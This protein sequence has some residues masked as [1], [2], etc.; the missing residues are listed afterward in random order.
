MSLYKINETTTISYTHT[1]L[2]T[3]SNAPTLIFLHFWGGSSST[4]SSLL[5]HLPTTIPTLILSFRGWGLSSGPSSPTS[6]SILHLAQDVE[7]LISHLDIK[8]FV[9]IGHSMGGKVAQLIAGQKRVKGLKGMV[10]LAPAPPTPLVL[11]EEMK[12]QQLT[13][14]D[15][16]ESAEFVVRNVLT[17]SLISSSTIQ[18]LVQD[19]LSGNKYAK[20]AWPEYAMA[21]DISDEAKKVNVPVLVVVG[22]ED[23]VETVERVRKEVIGNIKGAYMIV[24]DGKG[25]LLPVEAPEEVGRLSTKVNWPSRILE[26]RI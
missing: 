21:E 16:P 23:R 25:H 17:S 15:T 5:T 7:A 20:R 12:A 11:S 10:L 9:L 18:F 3:S 8:N 6:Y 22:E 4:F 19:M 2:H 13:A 26:N 14:Y 24:L 1:P